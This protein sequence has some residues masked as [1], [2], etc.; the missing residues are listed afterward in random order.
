M[1]KDTQIYR[2]QQM[3]AF[4]RKEKGERLALLQ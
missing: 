2:L 1:N 3:I 4:L